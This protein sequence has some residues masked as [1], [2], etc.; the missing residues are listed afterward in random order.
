MHG[1]GW[2]YYGGWGS[3]LGPL[4]MLIFTVL[5]VI[6]LVLL[7]RYLVGQGRPAGGGGGR[8]PM[9]ILKERYA[10][11]EITR[12]QYERMRDDLKG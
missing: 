8:Q 11:G 5:V 12:E 7:I 6:G 10:R 4:F 2:G 9:D 3:W 1:W